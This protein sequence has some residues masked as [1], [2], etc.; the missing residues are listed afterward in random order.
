MNDYNNDLKR[1]IVVEE[2]DILDSKPTAVEITPGKLSINPATII[3]IVVTLF[4]VFTM[5]YNNYNSNK[6]QIEYLSAL[7]SGEMSIISEEEQ[8]KIQKSIADKE[9]FMASVGA[10]NDSMSQ[11]DNY[12]NIDNSSVLFKEYTSR[13]DAVKALARTQY[14]T[15]KFEDIYQDIRKNLIIL[16]SFDETYLSRE[17][18]KRIV[19][20]VVSF[21]ETHF[22]FYEQT[23]ESL[24]FLINNYDEI[25]FTSETGKKIIE[26]NVIK[27]EWEDIE[28]DFM[29]FSA[30]LRALNLKV[31]DNIK[32]AVLSN[33]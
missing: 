4:S 31:K 21:N 15:T 17:A 18:K 19:A 10:I 27:S 24:S 3:L 22:K 16:A 6:G 5:A 1:E 13:D 33:T 20:S 2:T 30:E 28:Q 11:L 9:R 23:A 7:S 25:D 12:F 29:R 32:N 26:D 14:H 8:S